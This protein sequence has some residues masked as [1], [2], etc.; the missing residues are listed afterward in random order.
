MFLLSPHGEY[1]HLAINIM[2]ILISFAVPDLGMISAHGPPP[3]RGPK[4]KKPFFLLVMGGNNT[5]I[6]ASKRFLWF[7]APNWWRPMSRD[8]A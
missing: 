4:P 2:L 1:T 8:H 6:E 3:I 5:G 7:G